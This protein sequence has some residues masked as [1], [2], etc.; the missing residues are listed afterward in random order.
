MEPARVPGHGSIPAPVARWWL[1]GADERSVWLRRLYTAP[2]GRA[3]VAM[4]SRRRLFTGLLRRMRVLRDDLC[5]TPW[6]GAAIT[7]ADHATPAREGVPTD[8]VQ[9]NGKCVRC[10]H[11]KEA[12]GWRTRTTPAGVEIRTPLGW[13]YRSSPPPLL[14]WGSDPPDGPA[15]GHPASVLE[16]HLEAV[17]GRAA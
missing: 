2:S 17:L 9:G 11:S 10:S 8:F 13:V 15:R 16:D 6:C 12:P 5:T 4:D 14:G 7:H 3:L 1:R